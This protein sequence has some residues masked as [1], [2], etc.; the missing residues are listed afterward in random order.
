MLFSYKIIAFFKKWIQY[1]KFVMESS[2]KWKH[3]NYLTQVDMQRL[4]FSLDRQT[5]EIL[6]GIIVLL[7][8]IRPSHLVGTRVCTPSQ[9]VNN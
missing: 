5:L 1:L 8:L 6:R 4:R 2:Y 3:S 7:K 9:T